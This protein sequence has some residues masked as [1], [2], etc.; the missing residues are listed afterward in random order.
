M[1]TKR[2][3]SGLLAA[4][5]IFT[6]LPAVALADEAD[7]GSA[8]TL[9]PEAVADENGVTLSK[10]AEQTALDEYAITMEISGGT[11]KTE[12]NPMEIV[13]AL[14]CS[15]SMD[16]KGHTYC[17]GE[18]QLVSANRKYDYYEIVKDTIVVT[19]DGNNVQKGTADIKF[20]KKATVKCSD[21]HVDKDAYISYVVKNVAIE[22]E[23]EEF[24]F[25]VFG[26]SWSDWY[27]TQKVSP[28]NNNKDWDLP[29]HCS[30]SEETKDSR[31]KLARAAASE[32]VDSLISEKIDAKI[33]VVYFAGEAV[34][35]NSEWTEVNNDNKA[36][37]K[38]W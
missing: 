33:K 12:R 16:D 20:I 17:D 34:L 30:H 2:F 24:F 32:F 31:I 1:N 29:D 4:A 27:V 14:D 36:A 6:M 21:G 22:R 9:T 3:L 11:T 18:V 15:S 8:I 37:I 28:S 23:Y 25:G 10:V 35:A 19:E 5:M 13:L 38:K 26:G 7:G